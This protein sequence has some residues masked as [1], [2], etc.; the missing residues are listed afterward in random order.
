MSDV[1]DTQELECFYRSTFA[2]I[3][4]IR[5]A[6]CISEDWEEKWTSFEGLLHTFMFKENLI[7]DNNNGK[8][9]NTGDFLEY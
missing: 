7:N 2:Q 5:T 9:K 6:F 4:D 8:M 3:K 1:A